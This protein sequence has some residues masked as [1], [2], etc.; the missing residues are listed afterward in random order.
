[1]E[2]DWTNMV[3]PAPMPI[4]KYPLRLVARLRIRCVVKANK[5]KGLS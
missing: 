3:M 4:A 5:T 2:D 1:M